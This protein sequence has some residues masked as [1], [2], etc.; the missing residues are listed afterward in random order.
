LSG[1]GKFAFTNVGAHHVRGHDIL[2]GGL[3]SRRAAFA[4]AVDDVHDAIDVPHQPD[5]DR[6]EVGVLAGGGLE[7]A[8]QGQGTMASGPTVIAG[9]VIAGPRLR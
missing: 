7:G 1:C 9:V 4:E 2:D 6:N 8:G 5:R 3:P